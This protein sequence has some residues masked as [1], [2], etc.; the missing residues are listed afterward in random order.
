MQGCVPVYGH[1]DT[2]AVSPFA[3]RYLRWASLDGGT[4]IFADF[5]VA[6]GGWVLLL[7][8][9]QECAIDLRLNIFSGACLHNS[10]IRMPQPTNQSLINSN[11][12]ASIGRSCAFCQLV[13]KRACKLAELSLCHARPFMQ[14][15]VEHLLSSRVLS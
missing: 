7:L 15:S 2:Q 10:P 8:P 11:S 4:V 14:G 9:Y 6:L 3:I 1:I 12:T 13:W 5:V